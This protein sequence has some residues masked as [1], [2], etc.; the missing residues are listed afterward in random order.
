M[1]TS[2]HSIPVK[3]GELT[4]FNKIDL[5]HKIRDTILQLSGVY[6]RLHVYSAPDIQRLIKAKMTAK[7]GGPADLK[8]LVELEAA[9][10]EIRL[11]FAEAA[12]REN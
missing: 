11:G 3:G 2:E 7:R 5:Y 1:D 10:T 9:I 12:A 4:P 8:A 6:S